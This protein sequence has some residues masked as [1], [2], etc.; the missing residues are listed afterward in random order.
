[1][2]ELVAKNSNLSDLAGLA[3]LLGINPS[4]SFHS[5]RPSD[6]YFAIASWTNQLFVGPN[7]NTLNPIKKPPQGRFFYWLG[8]LDSN[9]RMTVS[10]TVALPLGDSPMLFS[11]LMVHMAHLARFE[12]TTLAFGGQYSIQLSYKC[13]PRIKSKYLILLFFDNCKNFF[14][15]FIFFF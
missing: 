9:Q 4:S 3:G 10:K 14:H 11:L 8:W 15:F 6:V 12:L 13:K 7:P 1:M 5:D 2:L